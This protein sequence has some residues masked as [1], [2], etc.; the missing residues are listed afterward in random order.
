MSKEVDQKG[1]LVSSISEDSPKPEKPH[2]LNLLK[3]EY[4][5]IAVHLCKT[6]STSEQ[7]PTHARPAINVRNNY[8]NQFT[9]LHQRANVPTRF[10]YT[11][12]AAY[13]CIRVYARGFSLSKSQ[14]RK[15]H[16]SK[17]TSLPQP[18]NESIR[19]R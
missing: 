16:L 18:V 17:L 14:A 15:V 5:S 6:Q 10:L 2:Q 7:H 9:Y 1:S 12:H 3:H 19:Q 8:V 11:R 13:V 4:N